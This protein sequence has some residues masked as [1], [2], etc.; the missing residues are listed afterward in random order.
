[1]DNPMI[2]QFVQQL[3]S[4]AGLDVLDQAFKEDYASELAEQVERHIG[5]EAVK[6][7]DFK[8]KQ[9]YLKIMESFGEQEPD[10]EQM[11]AFF[12]QYVPDFDQKMKNTLVNFS[13]DFLKS[14]KK[15]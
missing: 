11:H 12:L 14:I 4:D 5:I 10:P 9:E 15:E 13:K 7:L 1:M 2:M 6:L 8:G 3:M